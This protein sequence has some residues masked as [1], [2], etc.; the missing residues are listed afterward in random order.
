VIIFK[1]IQSLFT[2]LHSDGT[3]GQVAAGMALGAILGLV[4]GILWY[5]LVVRMA[6]RKQYRE[7]RL[8]IVARTDV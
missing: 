1:L 8:A 7:F 3:P 5:I 6:L 2:T 4:I